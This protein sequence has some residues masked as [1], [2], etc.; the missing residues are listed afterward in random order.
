MANKLS[1]LVTRM[2][3]VTSCPQEKKESLMRWYGG[4]FVLGAL[5]ALAMPPVSF[6]PVLFVTLSGLL[7][8]LDGFKRARKRQAFI[9]GWSFAWGYFIA[10]LY[11]IVYAL[12]V[13][14][15]KFFW[16]VPFTLLGLPA[17]LAIFP[18]VAI[19]LTHLSRTQGLAKCLVFSILWVTFE[20]L[21]GHIFT[22]LPWNLAGYSWM[23]CPSVLQSVSVIGVYGLS[24][25]TVLIGTM[26]YAWFLS[27]QPRVARPL[28]AGILGAFVIMT[29]AGYW[30]LSNAPPLSNEGEIVRIVQPNIKQEAKW[31]PSLARQNFSRLIKLSALPSKRQVQY[32]IWPE[33]ATPFF[34][35]ESPEALKSIE[36]LLPKGSVLFTGAPRRQVDSNGKTV[37]IWNSLLIVNDGGQ[38]LEAYDKS[39]LVPFGEYVP[40]RAYLPSWVRKITY[41]S[42]DYSAGPSPKTLVLPNI[43]PFSPLICYEVIFPGEVVSKHD[44]RPQWILNATND[45]WYGYTSGPFQHAAIARMRAIEEGVPLVRAANTGISLVVDAYG[46]QVARLGLEQTGV[47]DAVLPQALAGETLYAR[48]GDKTL[49]LMILI[50]GILSF[51]CV[52]LR[53]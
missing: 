11:W 25:L 43:K 38:V 36:R 21:R 1:S 8:V 46:R 19:L 15:S 40:W 39:H 34:L 14:L 5:T 48:Y 44:Q 18:A 24:L 49:V 4:L 30:R 42:L 47:L 23:P 26:P 13:D 37:A 51:V 31:D 7:W 35:D 27:P 3:L 29:A 53:L 52:R 22:G 9:A 41:G 45:G 17:V 32:L 6:F 12:G 10:G 50:L 20:W 28:I 2:N 16:L 33:S